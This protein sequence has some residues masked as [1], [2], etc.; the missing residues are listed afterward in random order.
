M[1]KVTYF[2]AEVRILIR[3]IFSLGT[4]CFS[5]DVLIR[6]DNRMTVC[7]PDATLYRHITA[8]DD[9]QT[10]ALYV[11][12]YIYIYMYVYIYIYIAPRGSYLG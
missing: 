11:H 9:K 12:V 1:T 4:L 7:K 3:Y 10:Y 6:V 8:S 2:V 5:S